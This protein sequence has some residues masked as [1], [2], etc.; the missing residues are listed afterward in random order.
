MA[1]NKLLWSSKLIGVFFIMLVCTLSA[2][3]QFLRTSYFMEGTHYRQQLNPALTPTKGYFNLPVIG[4]VNATVGSTSLGYQDIIDII[5]DGD[6]FYTKPDFMNR[7]KDNNKLNVNFSTEILSA[8]WYK[9]KNF[10]SFNIGLRTD[11]GANLTKNMFT[12]LNEM[13]TVEENWRNS[14]YDISG[15]QLNINAYTEIGLGLSRQINSRLT[16]GAR[17]KA[18]LGIGNMELKLNRVAMSANLP[19]DQQINQ[20]SSESYWNSMTPSQAAQAAQELKDKFNNYHANLTVGAELKS[21]FKG[22]ELQEEE[23]KD[24][25]TD[26]DFDSGKLGIAGYGFGIDLGASYKILDNLTVSASVLDLGFISW[27]KSST[28]IA[29]ANPD[30]IDIKGSTY[31]NMVDPNNPNTVMNAVNQLQNDAQGYMD[32]V[33]NGDVLDYDMLQLEVSDAKESRK[34]RLASILVLGAEYG[35]F[36]NKLAVGVLSTTRF[37]QPD[38]LTEL[39]FSA[40]YRPKSWFNVALSYSAIQSAGKSFGLGLKLGPLFVGTD[41]MFLGKNSNSVNGFVGVS[42]PLGGRKASKEG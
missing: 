24:Y 28:K 5:D 9:G 33:T 1:T 16:V 40:N 20:W 19:S 14:N 29:S 39:T 31:A 25:V 27:S 13:E 22:L 35:F 23:G 11:I 7:L 36:N 6:D 10:W 4:A 38:A 26:F 12:F 30:P 42:I 32:R 8:G 37:V 18:L 41:Y 21:S 2:N 3:A 15:Q 34:S 17:V